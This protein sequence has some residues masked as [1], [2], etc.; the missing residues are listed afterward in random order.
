[1]VQPLV[2]SLVLGGDGHGTALLRSADTRTQHV[3]VAV[4]GRGRALVRSYDGYGRLLTTRWVAA[5]TVPVSV[6]PGGFTLV[7]R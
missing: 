5:A 7:R 3:R 6:A 1:M 4:P 2:T